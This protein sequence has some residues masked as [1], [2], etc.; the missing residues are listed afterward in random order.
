MTRACDECRKKKVKCDGQQPCVHCTTYSYVCTYNQPTKRT[1]TSPVGLNSSKTGTDSGSVSKN[2]S[3]SK[4][5]SKAKGTIKSDTIIKNDKSV[6]VVTDGIKPT[7]FAGITQNP[8]ITATS[9][10]YNDMNPNFADNDSVQAA[11][12]PLESSQLNTLTNEQSIEQKPIVNP[13]NSTELS[14]QQTTNNN[15]NGNNSNNNSSNSIPPATFLKDSKAT[16]STSSTPRS[17]PATTRRFPSKNLKLQGRLEKYRQLLQG[18]IPGLPD[19][20]LLDVP[21]FLRIFHNFKGN[22][23]LFDD[24]IREYNLIAPQM[25]S[26]PRSLNYN[27]TDNL[28]LSTRRNMRQSYVMNL[29]STMNT[30]LETE[31]NSLLYQTVERDIKIILPPKN[32]ALRFVKIAWDYCCVLLRFYHRPSFLEQFNEL[33]ATDPSNYTERMKGFLALCYST[34]AVGALFSKSVLQN[35]EG[36][37]KLGETVQLIKPTTD[38]AV[39]TAL[40]EN[41]NLLQTSKPLGVKE[42]VPYSSPNNSYFSTPETVDDEREETFLQDEGYRYFMAARK[43][44]DITDTRDLVSIE[45]VLM[46]F[47]YLQCSARLSTC[48]T[49][50]AVAMRS[51]LREGLHRVSPPEAH[52]DPIETE[53]RKRLFYTIYKLDIYV[54]TMLG[55]PR[56]LLPEDFDQTLPVELSDVNITVDGYYPERQNNVLSSVAISNFHTKLT[57]IIGEIVKELYPIKKSSNVISHETVSKLEMKL[58]NWVAQ[59]PPELQP[60]QTNIPY[61]YERANKLLHLALLHAQII[62]YRPFIHFLSRSFSSLAPDP[63]SLQCAK[64]SITVARNAVRLGKQMIEKKLLT[65]SYWFSSYTIFYAVSTLFFYMHEANLPDKASAREYYEVLTDAEDG[66]NLLN[67]VRT[68]SV[69]ASRIYDV[70][71]K[72]FEKL[73]AKTFQ[74]ISP[75]RI[76]S[77]DPADVRVPHPVIAPGVPSHIST[78]I[79]APSPTISRDG[80][81]LETGADLV[82]KTPDIKPE[83]NLDNFMSEIEVVPPPMGDQYQQATDNVY[84]KAGVSE[85]GNIPDIGTSHPTAAAMESLHDFDPVFN[86]KLA[87][88]TDKLHDFKTG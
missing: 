62:L 37:P 46:L 85:N 43:L 27:F 11:T 14:K 4:A 19:I 56:S 2:K 33:Y 57:M 70:L 67:H 49:Y 12:F 18:M 80:P 83:Y 29:D 8:T 32:V 73:N 34:I 10:N 55:L 52:L 75:W 30:P 28:P 20:E 78:I 23:T 65:G 41:I 3:K 61:R 59:L 50:L 7:D 39:P 54:N 24:V 13:T 5:K 22:S 51:A 58:E 40:P 47:I 1:L 79:Q 68:S 42:E 9:P 45:T 77:V 69:A 21:T 72:L 64:N 35:E 66:R 63:L 71:N 26:S 60:Y 76:H 16:L 44:I 15:N 38:G 25:V 48:Y 86:G 53:T 74:M 6:N 84:D 82:S 31:S 36:S 88:A 87:G 17:A 81:E